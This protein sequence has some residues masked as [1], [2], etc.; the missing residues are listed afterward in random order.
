MLRINIKRPQLQFARLARRSGSVARTGKTTIRTLGISLCLLLMAG[1]GLLGENRQYV[2]SE[3]LPPIEVP[4]DLS[5]P[6]TRTVFDIPGFS[7][8]QLVGEGTEIMPPRVPTSEEA[9]N[10]NSRIQFG[11]TGLYLEVDDEAASVWRRLGFALNRDQLSIQDTLQD[12]RR[13]RITFSHPPITFDDRNWF[14]RTVFFWRDPEII[15]Y[16]GTYLIEVQPEASQ[17]TRVVLLDESGNVVPMERADFVL[18]R[19]Q[20]RLG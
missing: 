2:G 15:N 7:V 18:S 17:R 13:Y 8:P 11:A 1:C 4:D 20:R 12:E 6:E 3:E 19:L 10:A 5:T 14:S 9:E 16:S